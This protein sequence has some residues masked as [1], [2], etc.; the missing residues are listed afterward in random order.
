MLKVFRP[1]TWELLNFAR[2]NVLLMLELGLH[3]ASLDFLAR[4]Y[5]VGNDHLCS[6]CL[7]HQGLAL[8]LIC[9]FS[10]SLVG[11]RK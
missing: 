7:L 1:E 5:W 3:G 11:G 6:S 2:L 9:I 8:L 10:A 4:V